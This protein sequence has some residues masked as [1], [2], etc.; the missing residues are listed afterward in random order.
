VSA[1]APTELLLVRHGESTWNAVRRWQGHGDPP[2]SE[3]GREQSRALAASLARGGIT[4]LWSSDLQRAVETAAIVAEVL[5]LPVQSDAR[6][7]ER[8]LGDWTG[9][10]REA[11][12]ARWPELYAR[13][14]AGDLDAAPPGGESQREL[15]ARVRPAAAE[16][17]ARHPGKRVLVVTHR[18]AIR[19]LAPEVRASNAELVRVTLEAA[20]AGVG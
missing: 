3:L 12:Q 2:L 18:G 8:H 20:A 1:R 5:G 6:W 17:A 16:L 10:R 13:L 19:V 15:D 4:A 9:L 14:A 7:R 11:I